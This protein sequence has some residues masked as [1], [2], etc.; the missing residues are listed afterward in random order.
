[1]EKVQNREKS[2]GKS[3]VRRKKSEMGHAYTQ[4]FRNHMTSLVHTVSARYEVTD[5]KKAD[6]IYFDFLG[7]L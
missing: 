5:R 2:D 7:L 1:M 4:I 3:P 6:G